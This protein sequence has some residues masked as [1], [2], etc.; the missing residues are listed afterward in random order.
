MKRTPTTIKISEF[1]I[2]LHHFLQNTRVYDS[3]CSPEARVW[4]LEKGGGYFLKRAPRGAL[5]DEAQMTRYFHALGL[6][7]ELV[8]FHTEG[9][10]DY[11]LTARVP[12]EDATHTQYLSDPERLCDA[13]ATHLRTLHAYSAA[14]CPITDHTA[15]YLARARENRQNGI[16]DRGY[17]L[18]A[19]SRMTADEAWAFVCTERHRLTNDTLLHGDYCLPNILFDNWRFS[20]FIDLGNG[21]IGDRHVDLYWGAW[22]LAF[23]LGTDRYRDRFFDA[24]GRD[25]IDPD[26]IALISAIECFG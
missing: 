4:F 9:E 10:F 12:G 16:F 15:K 7:A 13:I 14:G 22:T 8:A 23:N 21:G 17:L 3:S 2:P 20:G 11:L 6:S 19:L 5:L 18:P 25:M 24:Y 1:P 26:R